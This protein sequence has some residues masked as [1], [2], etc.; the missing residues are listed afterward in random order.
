MK[1]SE[2]KVKTSSSAQNQYLCTTL[3][4][5]LQSLMVHLRLTWTRYKI[6]QAVHC[7]L[8][9]AL[10]SQTENSKNSNRHQLKSGET[11]VLNLSLIVYILL[12]CLSLLPSIDVRPYFY[13][14][15]YEMF[16]D[17]QHHTS[18]KEGIECII[19]SS[20]KLN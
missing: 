17:S 8:R 1:S 18:N 6:I 14:P 5:Q 15:T 4:K 19:I 3:K 12:Y 7:A 20:T 11:F 2:V 16:Y 9:P 13:N 10:I